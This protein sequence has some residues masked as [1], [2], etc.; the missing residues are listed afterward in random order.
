MTPEE[1]ARAANPAL[2]PTENTRIVAMGGDPRK[3]EPLTVDVQIREDLDGQIVQTPN[4]PAAVLTAII[5]IPLAG[6][7][8]GAPQ[9]IR[10]TTILGTDGRVPD[11]LAGRCP[12]LSAR[13]LIPLG[14]IAAPRPRDGD[15]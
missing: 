2:S 13:L 6:P 12:V 10:M 3:Y 11:P 4:G 14:R 1:L 9:A 15:K 8:Q 7:G 5:V